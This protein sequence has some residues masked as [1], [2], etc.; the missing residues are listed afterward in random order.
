MASSG[1]LDYKNT[2]KR[3]KRLEG[4][5]FIEPVRAKDV[6]AEESKHRAKYYRITEAGMFQLFLLRD[7]WIPSSLQSQLPAILES[8]GDFLIFKTLLYPN[9]KKETLAKLP[10]FR[11]FEGDNIAY[12]EILTGSIYEVIKAIYQYLRN[13]CTEIFQYVKTLLEYLNESNHTL[14]DRVGLDI[15]LEYVSDYIS[16]ER[17]QFVM[18]I[19]LLFRTCDEAMQRNVFGI[20]AEDDKFMKVTD[21]LYKD[22][23]KSFNIAMR[24]GRRI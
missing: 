5:G 1:K 9:F 12:L 6:T 16:L 7:W 18:K 19:L 10:S 4:L 15:R 17:D 13:C 2:F 8:H 23:E 20:L 14:Q 22:F 21:D 11:S 3:V 24:M